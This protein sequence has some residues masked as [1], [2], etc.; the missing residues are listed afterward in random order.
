MDLYLTHECFGSNANLVL[1]CHLHYPLPPD[2]DKSINEDVSDN[3]RDYRV[4]PSDSISFMS[5]LSDT[6][7]R[8]HCDLVSTF[9]V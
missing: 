3:I 2:I 1:N 5:V 6:S 9:F 8:L 7:D 4:D